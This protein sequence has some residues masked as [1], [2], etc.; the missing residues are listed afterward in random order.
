MLLNLARVP[1][2]LTTGEW[3]SLTTGVGP[4][5]PGWFLHH[6]SRVEGVRGYSDERRLSTD[7]RHRT[8][9]KYPSGHHIRRFLLASIAV[10]G[11][12]CLLPRL[13]QGLRDELT[14]R[15]RIYSVLSVPYLQPPSSP[16]TSK[17]CCCLKPLSQAHQQHNPSWPTSSTPRKPLPYPLPPTPKPTL[18]VPPKE[19][20]PPPSPPNPHHLHPPLHP[21][22]RPRH[23]GFPP[24]LRRPSRRPRPPPR[25]P[26]H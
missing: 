23:L 10:H 9:W 6:P 16:V 20:P 4:G 12:R 22:P 26:A 8:S 24:S 18:T 7:M 15:T 25:L 21:R 2:K 14:H 3:G 17:T 19:I 5:R 13:S 1:G 11:A